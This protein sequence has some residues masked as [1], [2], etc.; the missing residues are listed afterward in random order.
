VGGESI[1]SIILDAWMGPGSKN[2]EFSIIFTPQ[3]HKI[4]LL[5]GQT[6]IGWPQDTKVYIKMGRGT[7]SHHFKT[8]IMI[9][10][11]NGGLLDPL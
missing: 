4:Q 2:L 7:L 6:H 9:L 3:S 5:R 11:H 8:K 10:G 1:G